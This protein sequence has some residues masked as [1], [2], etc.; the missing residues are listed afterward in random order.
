[1]KTAWSRRAWIGIDGNLDIFKALRGRY[2]HFVSNDG[3]GSFEDITS[4]GGIGVETRFIGWGDDPWQMLL[5]SEN[6]VF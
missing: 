5:S 4:R 3:E 2:E 1:M 6:V